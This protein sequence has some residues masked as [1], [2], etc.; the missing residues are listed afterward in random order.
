M[1]L[2]REESEAKRLKSEEVLDNTTKDNKD[3]EKENIT[4]P[5]TTTTTTEEQIEE[6]E[7]EEKEE[8]QLGHQLIEAVIANDLDK[9]KQLVTEK[10]ADVR[11]NGTETGRTPLHYAAE[12]G[13]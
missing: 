2:L 6:Q 10:E 11:F 5:T 12:H 9:V 7:Q 8:L 13:H 3:F 4:E 1:D